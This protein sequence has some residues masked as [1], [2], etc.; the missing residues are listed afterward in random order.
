MQDNS[1]ILSEF[2]PP[3]ALMVQIIIQSPTLFSGCS[4]D[5]LKNVLFFVFSVIERPV[6]A[7]VDQFQV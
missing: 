5:I 2:G 1:T 6:S 7:A 4:K 3:A